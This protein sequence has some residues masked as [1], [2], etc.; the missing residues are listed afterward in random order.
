MSSGDVAVGFAE[1]PEAVRRTGTAAHAAVAGDC[2]GRRGVDPYPTACCGSTSACSYG[3]RRPTSS[4]RDVDRY[5]GGEPLSAIAGDL[6]HSDEY[7]DRRPHGDPASVLAG[8]FEDVLG[9]P[10][11]A[12]GRRRLGQPTR[13]WGLGRPG[14]RSFTESGA[15]VARTGPPLRSTRVPAAPPPPVTI[16]AGTDILAV[17]DPSCWARER[18]A[19]SVPRHRHRRQGR[20]SVL[21]GRPIVR[22][23]ARS[24]RS[25]GTVIVH[26]GT[27]GTVSP[28]VATS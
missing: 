5:I 12:G 3:S 22:A 8:L 27:N 16:M 17:G 18:V 13:G 11:V 26:L 23:L 6:L 19:A 9:S 7:R 28:S 20:P 10:S 14:C 4:T 21:R 2:R 25:P 1:S 24:A 15:V